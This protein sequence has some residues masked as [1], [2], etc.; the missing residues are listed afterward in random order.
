M[1]SFISIF[2]GG[3]LLVCAYDVL[4]AAPSG[5]S[6]KQVL[7]T[8]NMQN[9]PDPIGVRVKCLKY[10][11]RTFDGTCNNLCN[12]KLGA[13]NQPL[14]RLP[15]LVNP[16]AYEPNFQPRSSSAVAGKTLPNA[17]DI[18]RIGF[19]STTADINDTAPDFTHMTMTWGQFVDHDIT[20]TELIESLECG[21]NNEPCSN[22]DGCIGIDIEIGNELLGSRNAQCIPLR[23]SSQ[24]ADGEQVS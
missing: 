16:T 20:L 22:Q 12:T 8:L 10:K 19:N 21:P 18:S 15:S 23:R 5:N 6:A 17:R 9:C 1:A 2:L 24:N 13:I 7:D 3:L 4:Q 14:R 11:F